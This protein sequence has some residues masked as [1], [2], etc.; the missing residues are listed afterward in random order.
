MNIIYH[1]TCCEC[2]ACIQTHP[3]SALILHPVNDPPQLLKVTT[4]RMTLTTHVLY[5]CDQESKG[6]V[7]AQYSS[8]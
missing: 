4:D 1:L 2:M 3:N 5:H 7:Y 6:Y 8:A